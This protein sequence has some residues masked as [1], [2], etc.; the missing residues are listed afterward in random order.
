[1][2]NEQTLH[3]LVFKNCSKYIIITVTWP[4]VLY[5]VEWISSYYTITRDAKGDPMILANP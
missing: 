1:M 5:H 2:P 4:G 3:D